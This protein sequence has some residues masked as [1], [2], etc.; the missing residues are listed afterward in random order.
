M[1]VCDICNKRLQ[2]SVDK[3][4]GGAQSQ[5]VEVARSK[6]HTLGVV[7]LTVEPSSENKPLR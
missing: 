5:Q 7:T 6:G 4:L 3:A 2:V 1:R